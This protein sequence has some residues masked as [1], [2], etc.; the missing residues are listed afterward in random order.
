MTAFLQNRKAHVTAV[1]LPSTQAA[2]SRELTTSWPQD[3][4]GLTSKTWC[5]ILRPAP[6]AAAPDVE[7][8]AKELPTIR[9]PLCLIEGVAYVAT[10]LHVRMT[11]RESVNKAGEVVRHNP[12]LVRTERRPFVI[13]GDGRVFGDGGDAPIDDLGAEVVLPEIPQSEK[14]WSRDGLMA[15]RQ[16]KRPDPVTCSGEW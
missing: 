14:L 9:R 8:L 3:T 12:P 16:G 5:T 10:W 6:T 4:P 13:R 7:L 11:V 15:Y 2:A 1:Y